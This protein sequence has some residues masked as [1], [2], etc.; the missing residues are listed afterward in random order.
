MKQPSWREIAALPLY[1]AGVIVWAIAAVTLILADKVANKNH[2]W[3]MVMG[4]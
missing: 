4:R 2:G 1:L 3:K